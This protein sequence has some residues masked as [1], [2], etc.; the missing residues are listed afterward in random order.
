MTQEDLLLPEGFG[1]PSGS[2]QKYESWKL[3]PKDDEIQIRILP[4][5]K[6]LLEINDFGL[7]WRLHY[8]WN[9]KNLK[10]P[11][12]PAYHPFLCIE[13]KGRGGMVIQE[14]PACTY[15][16]SYVNKENG[17]KADIDTQLKALQD[18]G[19]AKGVSEAEI[20]KAV[21]AQREKLLAKVGDIKK[22]LKDHGS[23]GKFRIPCIN[24]QGDFG[25]FLAPYGVV[26]QIKDELRNLRTRVYPGTTINI[27]G[28]GR[29]GVWFKVVRSGYASPTSDKATICRKVNDDGSEAIEFHTVS[30]DQLQAAMQRIPD[31]VQ[32]RE[33]NRIRLDQIEALV[34]LDIDGGGKTLPEDVDVILELNKAPATFVAPKT[35]AEPVED[36]MGPD[37]TG[38]PAP[39]VVK[40]EP[41]APVVAATPAVVK[42]ATKAALKVVNPDIPAPAPAP[43]PAESAAPDAN[44]DDLWS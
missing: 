15:R 36:W 6:S 34:K 22:W 16:T 27:E 17:A 37:A 5:M 3:K 8:G 14:C 18:R 7:F 42:T 2:S 31:L 10:D 21:N 19:R 40:E 39:P 12:K 32:M 26:K 4:S 33:E 30:N 11:T 25:I 23:D 20:N 43:A 38:A 41:V 9:G 44:F 29:K 1:S 28:A 13:E 35:T 24:R